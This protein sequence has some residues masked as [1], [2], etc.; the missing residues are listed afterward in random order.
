MKLVSPQFAATTY[1][2]YLHYLLKVV[3]VHMG[4]LVQ[5][6]WVTDRDKESIKPMWD[7]AVA[8]F[9]LLR[10]MDMLWTFGCS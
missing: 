6:I 7:R 1:S 8:F 9:T 2:R 4:G 10:G 3:R 5:S